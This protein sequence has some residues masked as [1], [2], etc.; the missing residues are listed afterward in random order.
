MPCLAVRKKVESR[1]GGVHCPVIKYIHLSLTRTYVS[2]ARQESVVGF[3][4]L[5]QAPVEFGRIPLHPPPDGDMIGR[6]GSLSQELFDIT[7]RQ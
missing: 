1:T 3:E 2:S 5:A 6:A 4:V 7:V